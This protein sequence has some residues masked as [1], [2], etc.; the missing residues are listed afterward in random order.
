MI[1]IKADLRIEGST[2]DASLFSENLFHAD[3]GTVTVINNSDVQQ[4]AGSYEVTPRVD[5]ETILA[6]RNKLM[7]QNVRVHEIPRYDVSNDFAGT[8]VYI[9]KE[10]IANG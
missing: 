10:V 3:V 7:Q 4:Y 8:T 9:G 6:T 5:A 1:E 2:I